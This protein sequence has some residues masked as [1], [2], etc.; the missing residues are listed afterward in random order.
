MADEGEGRDLGGEFGAEAHLRG[1]R[2]GQRDAVHILHGR[3]LP[4]QRAEVRADE[5]DGIADSKLVAQAQDR[6]PL[7]VAAF[8][9][10][11]DL[12]LAQI[13]GI[14]GKLAGLAVVEAGGVVAVR[15]IVHR[16]ARGG[17]RR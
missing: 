4:G 14:L 13:A 2:L 1:A 7:R 15:D 9:D 6:V 8:H 3:D 11:A 10:G 12:P 5:L 16:R 17:R